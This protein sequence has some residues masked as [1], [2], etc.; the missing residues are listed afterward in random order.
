MG[1]RALVTMSYRQRRQQAFYRWAVLALLALVA[2]GVALPVRAIVASRGTLAQRLLSSQNCRAIF[3]QAMPILGVHLEAGGVPPA[4]GTGAGGTGTAAGE[5]DQTGTHG[6]VAWGFDLV[7]GVKLSDPA[8]LLA[9]NLPLARTSY[10]AEILA[11]GREVADAANHQGQSS[12]SESEIYTPTGGGLSPGK[13]AGATAGTGDGTGTAA[14]VDGVLEDQSAQL[15]LYGSGEPLIAIVHTHTSES[16]LPAVTALATA[17]DPGVDTSTLEAFTTDSSANMLR[18]GE[19]LARYLATA[20]GIP[21]VQSRRV[22]DAQSD[23]FRLGAYERS[24]ETMTE[25]VRRHPSIKIMIDLHRDAP[26]H[27]RTTADINGVSTATVCVIVGTSKLLPNPNAQ[28]N[29]DFARRLVST[30]EADFRGLS[31]GI[32][33]QDERYNQ[34][35]ME[36]T[37]LLEIGGQENTLEEEFASVHDLGDV[38]AQIVAEGF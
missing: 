13:P 1:V 2:L 21:V 6:L 5:D 20:H 37:M 4:S 25:I 9:A 18:V 22:H 35:V 10:A 17:R 3:R 29:Y 31:R 7:T 30:M 33:V 28:A 32:M 8:T 27:D 12:A 36:R 38:L 14:P 19:E 23:G 11:S 24:L 16:F 15:Y 34:H 26:S